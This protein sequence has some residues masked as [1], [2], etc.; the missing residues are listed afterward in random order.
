MS[1][2][3]TNEG[4]VERVEE[5]VIVKVDDVEAGRKVANSEGIL[6]TAMFSPPHYFPRPAGLEPR[7]SLLG[8]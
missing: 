5:D 4:W 7:A 2:A 6:P 1:K 3:N 8:L